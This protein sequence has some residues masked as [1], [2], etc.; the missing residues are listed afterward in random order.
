[1]GAVTEHRDDSEMSRFDRDGLRRF[2]ARDAVIAIALVAGI[3]VLLSGGS[4]LRAG[5]EEKPGV[6]KDV[7]TAVG[8]PTDAIASTLPFQNVSND[9][10]ASLSPDKDL[11]AGA[12]FKNTVAGAGGIPPVTPDA[13]NPATI[14]DKPAPKVPLGKLLITGDSLSQPLDIEL[15]Q[16]LEPDGVEVIRDP[17]PGT[18]ISNPVLVDWGQL[19]ATQVADEH[20]DAV[21]AFIGANEGYPLPGP[22]GKDVAC[23]GVDWA[24]I[25]A[26]RLRQ[27][28]SNYRQGG[29]A[30]VY[31]LTVPTPRDSARQ[32]VE[33]TVNEAI[34]VAAAP[35]AAQVHVIDT[36]P[37]FT[38]GEKYRDAMDVDGEEKIVRE[39][40]GIHLNDTGSEVAADVVLDALGQDFTF[41]P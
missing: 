19:S 20:P 6:T 2:R 7:L 18:G 1:M 34:K 35:W 21:V 37:V 26:N 23:C 31:W 30:E 40:D 10:T 8:K 39:S 3:L 13:F 32:R 9:I 22:N 38:P 28:M 27:M 17:H 41:G 33:R 4:V 14:G 11:V 36:V 16:A 25:F 12:E 5:K 15:A 29:K 24:V